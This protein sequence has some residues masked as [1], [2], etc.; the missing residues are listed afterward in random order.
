MKI[1]RGFA[2]SLAMAVAAPGARAD[3]KPHAPPPSSFSW[4]GFYLGANMGGAI[5]LHT[6]E[7]LQAVGGF[8]GPGFDLYPRSSE[9]SGP[10]FGAQL[11]YNWQFANWVYGVETDFNFLGGRRAPNGTFPTPPVYAAM[12]VGSFTLAPKRAGRISPVI[13]PN[14]ASPSSARSIM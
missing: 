9:R 12:G 5:P 6:G 7:S 3:D 1:L 10:T 13:A 11:G 8:F 4:A 14:S 2:L